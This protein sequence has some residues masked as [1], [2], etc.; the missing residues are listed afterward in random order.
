M[1]LLFTGGGTGGH[2]FPGVAVAQAVTALEPRAQVLFA[3]PSGRGN[4][5][6]G[7]PWSSV[8]LPAPRMERLPWRWPL[9]AV[10]G[11]G[12]VAGVARILAGFRPDVVVGTGGYASAPMVLAAWMARIPVL[13]IE[14]NAVAGRA[15]RW[16]S[17]CAR[18]VDAAWEFDYEPWGERRHPFSSRTRLVVTGNPVRS[19]ILAL[20]DEPPAAEPGLL[21]FGG[22]LGASPLNRAAVEAL[23]EVIRA[24]PGLRVRHVTGRRDAAWAARAYREA[25]VQVEVLDFLRDMRPAYREASVVVCRAGGNTLA[26]VLGLGRP[27]VVVP[28]PWALDDHQRANALQAAQRGAAVMVEERHLTPA[29]LAAEVSRLLADRDACR[30]M[31]ERGRALV[32]PDAAR[33]VAERVILL[34][35]GRDAA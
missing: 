19:E 26:E 32:R 14:P 10:G 5:L 27:A 29:R 15:N 33:R 20:G 6:R 3:L 17:R 13:L 12:A 18:E 21:V 28:Y 25:G 2:V 24:F 4:F 8:T 11:L 34:A 1:R 16:L 22:S 30:A 23:P 7:T 9:M 31:G 35:R